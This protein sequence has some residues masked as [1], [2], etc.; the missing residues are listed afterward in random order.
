MPG[1]WSICGVGCAVGV[2]GVARAVQQR[3][4]V[5]LTGDRRVEGEGG[6]PGAGEPGGVLLGAGGKRLDT[7]SGRHLGRLGDHPRGVTVG[8]P[9]PFN[10]LPLRARRGG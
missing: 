7:A 5:P 9:C 2:P 8:A 1:P 6:D 10:A 3:V 4:R